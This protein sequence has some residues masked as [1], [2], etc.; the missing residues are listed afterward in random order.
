MDFN[1]LTTR[2]QEAV[3]AAQELARRGG[4]PEIHPEHLLLALLEQELVGTL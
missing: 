4:Q 2:S 3:A 1:K